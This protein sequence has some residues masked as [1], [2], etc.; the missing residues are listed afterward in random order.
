M[1][2][3]EVPKLSHLAQIRNSGK[4]TDTKKYWLLAR[5]KQFVVEL[6]FN[7]RGLVWLTDYKAFVS[8]MQFYHKS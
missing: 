2:E 3:K 8:I 6:V 1:T 7:N 4:E 5:K